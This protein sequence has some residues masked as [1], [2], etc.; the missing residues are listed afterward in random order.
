MADGPTTELAKIEVTHEMV[1]AGVAEFYAHDPRVESGDEVVED[2]FVAMLD[3]SGLIKG[4]IRRLAR[5]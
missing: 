5:S 3:A 2:I 1:E 4:P